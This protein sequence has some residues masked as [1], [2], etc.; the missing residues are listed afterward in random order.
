MFA[1][2]AAHLGVP[3]ATSVRGHPYPSL[4]IGGAHALMK[5]VGAAAPGITAF[6]MT[7]AVGGGRLVLTG[8]YFLLRSIRFRPSMGLQAAIRAGGTGV[9]PIRI[10]ILM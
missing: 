4:I 9:I 2:M 1:L 3:S 6:I 5:A 8:F 10:T 7:E